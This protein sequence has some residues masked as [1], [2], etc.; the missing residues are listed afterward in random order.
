M[1]PKNTIPARQ[2]FVLII[3]V[4]A[5]AIAIVHHFICIENGLLLH[6]INVAVQVFLI[7]LIFSGCLYSLSKT[8]IIT[9]KYVISFAI[10]VAILC[11]SK[12]V[13]YVPDVIL[14]LGFTNYMLLHALHWILQIVVGIYFLRKK[15]LK[16]RVVQDDSHEG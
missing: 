8:R 12:M 5:F 15:T 6:P 2:M 14:R 4:L 13:L 7:S 9:C 10:A 11:I 3:V 1:K 16:P